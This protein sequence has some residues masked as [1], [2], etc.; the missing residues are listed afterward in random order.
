LIPK[1]D[2][3]RFLSSEVRPESV[4]FS[5]FES[6]KIFLTLNKIVMLISIFSYDGKLFFLLISH[7]LL[8]PYFFS[9]IFSTLCYRAH[10]SLTMRK[11]VV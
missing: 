4:N 6:L 3:F 1:V 2:I 8:L 7:L 11:V 10:L 5:G 9:R